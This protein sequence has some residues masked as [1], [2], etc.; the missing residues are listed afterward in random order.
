MKCKIMKLIVL[1]NYSSNDCRTLQIIVNNE[2]N[3][4]YNSEINNQ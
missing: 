4:A 3:N 1:I 2:N